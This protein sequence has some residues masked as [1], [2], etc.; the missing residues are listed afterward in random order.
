MEKHSRNQTL[1]NSDF[2]LLNPADFFNGKRATNET[3]L[4]RSENL[5]RKYLLID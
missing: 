4:T 5:V 1:L 2:S 3:T